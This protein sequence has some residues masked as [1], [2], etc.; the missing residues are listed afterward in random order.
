MEEMIGRLISGRYRLIAPLGEGGMATLWRAVDE[1]LDREVAVKLLRPQY[2][3]RPRLRR[4]ASSRRRASAG[5]ARAT[6]T[7]CRSTTTGTDAEDAATQFIVMQLVEGEDL[8]ALLRERG[9]LQ[10]DDAVRVA[11][12][13]ASALEAAHRRGH[14]PPRREAGEHPDHRRRRREGHRLRHR[15]RGDRGLA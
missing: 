12:G 14:R 2:S 7:S 10:T 11:I 8:A 13:V 3:H 4:A 5:L 9:R 15:P 6:R 1:Q